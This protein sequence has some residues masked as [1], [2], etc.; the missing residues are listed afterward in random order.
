MKKLLL[1]VALVVLAVPATALRRKSPAKECKTLH[2]KMGAQAF[3]TAFG[4]KRRCA[5]AK[6]KA[7]KAALRRARKACRAKGYRGRAMK[8]CMRKKLAAA[9]APKPADYE[10]AVEECKAE[11]ADDPEGFADEYGDGSNGLAKCVADEAADEE[12]ADEPGRRRGRRRASPSSDEDAEELAGRVLTP[13][14][15]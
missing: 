6:R 5:A 7:K 4:N 2:A 9:P 11:Q 13:E 10:D 8:R 14:E 15:L 1:V 3:Q 12:D